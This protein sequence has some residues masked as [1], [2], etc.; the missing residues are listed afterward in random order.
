MRIYPYKNKRFNKSSSF[1]I[2]FNYNRDNPFNLTNF[3]SNTQ[4]KTI[5]TNNIFTKKNILIKKNIKPKRLF[6]KKNTT[7]INLPGIENKSL[8]KDLLFNLI[9]N[10]Y[11][12]TRNIKITNTAKINL[13][14]SDKNTKGSF[15][16]FD[17]SLK[18]LYENNK[19]LKNNKSY[20][21][22]KFRKK[23][24]LYF[25]YDE[26]NYYLK[27]NSFC[28]NN[29][30]LLKNKVMFVK[31]IC[32][33]IYPKIVINRM[34]FMD[35]KKSK[36]IKFKVNSLTKKFRNKYYINR[37]KSPEEN[38]AFSR[39]YLKGAVYNEA[40][41]MKGNFIKLKKVMINGHLAT[42][43]AKHHDYINNYI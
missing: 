21:E 29:P 24:E 35:E 10:K 38:S 40:I 34:K 39:Y 25:D 19:F 37:Y 23:N 33:Y 42:Q 8:N 27:H 28:G 6:I 3:T 17:S 20:Q 15:L 7:L 14:S 31:N 2:S 36:E 18:P 5:N 16:Y 41:K 1:N 4:S 22:E 13:N 30:N 11:S 43:L 26:N 32:D 9:D 12:K